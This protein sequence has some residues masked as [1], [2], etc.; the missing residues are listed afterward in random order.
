LF[1]RLIDM[2]PGRVPRTVSLWLASLKWDPTKVWSWEGQ[3][4]WGLLYAYNPGFLVP[5]VMP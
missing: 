4:G 2:R 5:W 1:R 3:E